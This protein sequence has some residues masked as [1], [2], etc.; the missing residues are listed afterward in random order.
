MVRVGG[1]DMRHAMASPE[2]ADLVCSSRDRKFAFVLWQRGLVE[3]AY[4][5]AKES[6]K[7]VGC[8]IASRLLHAWLDHREYRRGQHPSVISKES[9]L[10]TVALSSCEGICPDAAARN[11][12]AHLNTRCA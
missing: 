1:E 3:A 7:E 5:W 10:P 9:F 2:D 4:K 8:E 6:R 11:R 12:D